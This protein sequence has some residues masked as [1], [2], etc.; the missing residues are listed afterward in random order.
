MF[1]LTMR[2]CVCVAELRKYIMEHINF[3][4]QSKGDGKVKESETT[5]IDFVDGI[6]AYVI[7]S[8]EICR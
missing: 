3:L 4:Y 6:A 7:N 5:Q 8:S 2:V 1:Y